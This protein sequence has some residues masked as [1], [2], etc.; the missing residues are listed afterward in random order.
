MKK[1]SSVNRFQIIIKPIGRRVSVTADT[2]LLQAARQ[3]GLQV[4]AVCGG[5][6]TCG[7]CTVHIISGDFSEPTA[8]EKKLLPIS[9]IKAGRRL[10]CQVFPSSDGVISFPAESLGSLQRLQLEG[11]LHGVTPNPALQRLEVDLSNPDP[12]RKQSDLTTLR[13]TLVVSG[14]PHTQIPANL[15]DTIKDLMNLKSKRVSLV[16]H[17]MDLVTALT[18]SRPL[19]GLAVDL[20]TTK[21]AAFLVNLENGVT[22]AADGMP[23]PQISYG[24]DVIS[25]IEFADSNPQGAKILRQSVIAGINVLA[26]RLS[27][28]IGA[29]VQEISDCVIGGN[30]VMHHLLAGLPV[31]GLGTAPYLPATIQPMKLAA[32]ALGL[33]LAP[34]ARV[35]LPPNIAGFVGGD[36]VAML[37]AVRLRE[38]LKTILALDIGTNTEVSLWHKGRHLTCSCAS[39][40]AFEGAHIRHGL[41]AIPGAIERVFIDRDII[42]VQTIADQPAIG[43]CGSGIVDAVAEMSRVG[44]LNSRGSFNKQNPL[45]GIKDGKSEFPLVNAAQSGTGQEITINRQ[46]V[47]QLQLAKA[48]IRSGIE[49]L[50]REASIHAED[51]D[52]VL[53]AGAFGSYLDMSNCQHIGLLPQLPLDRVRQV[54]NAA[55]AGTRAMLLSTTKR[56]E[57]EAML[58]KIEYIELTTIHDYV[59]FFTDAIGF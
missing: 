11:E 19:L 58:D 1:S 35:Y 54:G 36:H 56:A 12:A 34:Y 51:L 45:V 49:V 52:Q 6:G 40:P 27:H 44:A 23:N 3:A 20:G 24:E 48:A 29:Q 31:H 41:R 9:A 53:V 13:E 26:A 39:G 10:A 38:S 37:L 55:G 7:A 5:K 33:N 46:D 14:Y 43:I 30:T 28:Q 16:F 18:P 57:A 47:Q 17:G 8:S 2:T 32:S 25:R 59:D 42:K 21:L 15:Q 4:A 50:L 22:L